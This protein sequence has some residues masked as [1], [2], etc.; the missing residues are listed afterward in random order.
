LQIHKDTCELQVF[1]PCAAPHQSNASWEVVY[2][3][4]LWKGNMFLE[5]DFGL[6]R[7]SD[8]EVR[9]ADGNKTSDFHVDLTERLG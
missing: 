4:H 9:L 2:V 6:P 7:G 3:L 5:E 8:R 1:L